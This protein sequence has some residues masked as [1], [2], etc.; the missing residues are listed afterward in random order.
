M[1]N[2]IEI[3]INETFR[4][5]DGDR[6]TS[7]DQGGPL[8]DLKDYAEQLRSSRKD[9]NSSLGKISTSILALIVIFELL[10]SQGKVEEFSISSFTFSNSSI[11]QIFLP[12]VI[13]FLIY[14]AHVLTARAFN[15]DEAYYALMK[16]FAPQIHSN[17]LDILTSPI[18]STFWTAQ[19]SAPSRL[20]RSDE[21][22]VQL[23]SGISTLLMIT[24]LPIAFEAQ[25]Y[26]HL[27]GKFGFLDPLLW[28]NAALTAI[29]LLFCLILIISS[30]REANIE[31]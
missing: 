8:G 10:S 7:T 24:I 31:W 23:N 16:K 3:R 30:E 25:A 6:S 4:N 19:K 14:T 29:F 2:N 13:A 27:F 5:S 17:G 11:V 20:L 15:L 28:V 1:P 12:T 22:F 21:V 26:N 18:L 9:A